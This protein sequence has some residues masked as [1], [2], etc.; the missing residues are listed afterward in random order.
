[1]HNLHKLD[2]YKSFTF[3]VNKHAV[4]KS[5]FSSDMAY[6]HTVDKSGLMVIWKWSEDYLS[7]AYLHRKKFNK[8][9]EGK[10]I[11]MDTANAVLDANDNNENGIEEEV[12]DA[13]EEAKVY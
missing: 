5:F 1:M 2:D 4:I 8:I 12:A 11:G 10:S 7:E 13:V 3:T 6:L 9:K